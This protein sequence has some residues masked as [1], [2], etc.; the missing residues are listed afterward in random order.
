[1]FC[2]SNIALL[3]SLFTLNFTRSALVVKHQADWYSYQKTKLCVL[4]VF[5]FLWWWSC[6]CA[7][8]A[9]YYAQPVSIPQSWPLL[10]T[11]TCLPLYTDQ[12]YPP[13]VDYVYEETDRSVPKNPCKF[14][15]MITIAFYLHLL[16]AVY[17]PDLS[18]L[19]WLYFGGD[20]S[21]GFRNPYGAG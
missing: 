8:L 15:P 17:R 7:R 4:Q 18:S 14:F 13:Y 6:P 21:L 16:T 10:F 2:G 1:M 11:C 5:Y 20:R 9:L 12:I 19:C 3:H